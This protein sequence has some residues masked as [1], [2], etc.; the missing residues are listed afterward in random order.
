MTRLRATISSVLLLL[1]L[2]LTVQA[3]EA[4]SYPNPALRADT[5]EPYIRSDKLGINH[6]SLTNE[7]TSDSRYANALG[8]GA[9][10]NRWPIYWDQVEPELGEFQWANYDRLVTND[11]RFGLKINAILMGRPAFAQDGER[12][13]GLNEPIFSDGTDSPR[14]DKTLNPDNPWVNYVQATVERYMPGGTMAQAEDWDDEQGIRVWEIWNE[15][16]YPAFWGAS[17]RDYA[18]LLKISYIVIKQTDPDAQVMFGGLLYNTGDNWLARVLAVLQ[19]DPQREEFN[20]YMDLVGVHGYGYPWR[21]GWLVLYVRQT[22]RAY[23]LER[24]IWLNESGVPIWDDYP[25]PTWATSP[26]ERVMRAT[27]EQQAAF[28]I[29]SSAY[30]W[31]EGADVVFLHQ[32]YDD[33]GNQPAGTNFPI[34][35]GELCTGD[36]ICAGDAF[37]VFRNEASSICFSQHPEPGTARPVAQAY[38]LLATIFG[39]ADLTNP[40]VFTVA[41]RATIITFDDE[42]RSERIYVVWNKTLR[43]QTLDLPAAGDSATIYTLA[44]L[45]QVTAD[46][47][48]VYTLD[49]PPATP[50]N[51]PDRQPGDP[52]AIGG[53]PLILVE[54]VESFPPTLTQLEDALLRE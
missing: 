36:T 25:G 1:I 44:D 10:W 29:Q 48:G 15:P 39:R 45:G 51:Y 13:V 52:T 31:A 37:G 26:N 5:R 18:R 41:G 47:H 54:P 14:D 23:E 17:I 38:H 53:A 46:R 2:S 4:T 7:P 19:Q 27:Q 42:A 20:W 28:F 40:L 43:P 22:L 11:V 24:P 8:L 21:S 9:G 16:D 3:Q 34:H 33:C 6:I 30:A 50:D 35:E 32:L 12:I 49:L